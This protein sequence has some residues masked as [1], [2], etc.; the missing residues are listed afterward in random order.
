ARQGPVG[1]PFLSADQDRHVPAGKALDTRA[2]H[3][4]PLEVIQESAQGQHAADPTPAARHPEGRTVARCVL[5]TEEKG[6][7]PAAVNRRKS[8]EIDRELAYPTRQ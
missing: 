1:L 7:D 2:R 5:Q 4:A 3:P 6:A 8:G